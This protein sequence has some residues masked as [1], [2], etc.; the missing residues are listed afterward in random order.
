MRKWQLLPPRATRLGMEQIFVATIV[1]EDTGSPID[2]KFYCSRV[3]ILKQIVDEHNKLIDIFK[4]TKKD[5]K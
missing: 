5:I 3:D 1:Y 2:A 4:N